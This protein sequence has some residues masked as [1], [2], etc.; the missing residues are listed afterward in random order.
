MTDLERRQRPIVVVGRLSAIA[1]EFIGS[2]AA[3]AWA[4]YLLDG[5]FGTQPWL[6]IMLTLFGT[7]TGFY[8]MVRLLR[9]F[10]KTE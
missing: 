3:G 7:S 4:G 8:R 6:L 1:F 5:R 9:H 2:V 10:Q